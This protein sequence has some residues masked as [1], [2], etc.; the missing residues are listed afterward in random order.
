ML[1]LCVRIT[2]CVEETLGFLGCCSMSVCGELGDTP[3]DRERHGWAPQ[4]GIFLGLSHRAGEVP[5]VPHRAT[6]R[7]APSLGHLKGSV[8]RS[9]HT[10][11]QRQQTSPRAAT[12]GRVALRGFEQLCC[13]LG[14]A[15][16]LQVL[17]AGCNAQKRT[18]W[19]LTN[20]TQVSTLCQA[21]SQT[22][23]CYAK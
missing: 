23:T 8:R 19:V 21:L 7:W 16:P 18:V 3:W 22:S 14:E 12:A 5:G 6:P 20:A 9:S 10:A 13:W 4:G 17:G 1:L 11:K 15:G 2:L